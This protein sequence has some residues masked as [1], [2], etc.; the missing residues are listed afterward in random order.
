MPSHRS[1]LQHAFGMI[2]GWW[3]LYPL[4]ATTL[5]FASFF[6]VAILA[7]VLGIGFEFTADNGKGPQQCKGFW[8]P[9]NWGP[10]FLFATPLSALLMGVYFRVLDNA[11]LSLD[12]IVKPDQPDSPPF[13]SLLA[14]KLRYAWPTWIYPTCILCSV[15]LTVISDGRDIIAPLESQ[16]IKPSKDLDWSTMGYLAK[17]ERKEKELWYLLF[18]IAAFSLQVFVAYCGF[19]LLLLTGYMLGFCIYYGLAGRELREVFVHP[20]V[21]RSFQFKP[22]WDFNAPKG[23]CGL[24]LLDDVYFLYV[25]L[26]FVCLGVSITSI[27]VREHWKDWKP[28]P[29]VGSVILMF[30]TV[31][32]IPVS[33]VW[34]LYPYYSNFPT[35]L[36]PDLKDKAPKPTPWPWGSEKLTWGFIG[37]AFTS[38]GYLAT[39]T[40]KFLLPK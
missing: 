2:H 10:L 27:V 37:L 17:P 38:W 24:H 12:H 9:P 23:R 7:Q 20:D 22:V 14:D 28:E 8:W 19:V 5:A 33:F 3:L 1:I 31:F 39:Q 15:L 34:I 29:H 18:N 25:A 4:R 36:P 6:I 35:E 40:V 16:V 32:F 13:S 26:N 21:A 11:L 30:G